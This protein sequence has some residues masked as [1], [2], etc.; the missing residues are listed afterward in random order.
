MDIVEQRK[1]IDQLVEEIVDSLEAVA[2][3]V[4][5]KIII[6]AYDEN[7]DHVY[8]AEESNNWMRSW[9]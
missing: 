5:Y 9:C 6:E 7:D 3:G 2:E 1:K 8:S 4:D